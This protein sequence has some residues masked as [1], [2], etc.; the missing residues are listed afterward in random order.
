[1]ARGE[2]RWYRADDELLA[3]QWKDKKVVTMLSAFRSAEN[4]EHVWRQ[5]K[6]KEGR[7]EKVKLPRP[8][9]VSDYNAHMGGVDLSDQYINKYNVL[10]KVNRWW[11]TLF[12]HFIDV[13][14]ASGQ[15]LHTVPGV[16]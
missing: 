3:L 5:V 4:Y 11:L 9:V 7:W 14:V 2:V 8:E 1:M 13:A 10:R 16:A 12:F 6:N 15:Q